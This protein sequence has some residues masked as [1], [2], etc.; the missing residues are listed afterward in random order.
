MN[1]S[2]VSLDNKNNK[3]IWLLSYIS[4]LAGLLFTFSGLSEFFEVKIKGNISGYP[5]GSVNENPWYYQTPLTYSTYNLISG[6]L[7]LAATVL[8][9]WATIRRNKKALLLGV[10]STIFLILLT[11]FSMN[12]IRD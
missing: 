10:G 4:V 11:L 7:F 1:K 6:I 5:W 3:S 2:E 12:A 9:F 8:T